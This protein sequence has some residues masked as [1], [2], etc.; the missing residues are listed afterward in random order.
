MSAFGTAVIR[1]QLKTKAERHS[2]V[3]LPLTA[4]M[5]YKR[6]MIE[7]DLII[8]EETPAPDLYALIVNN[9]INVGQGLVAA[10]TALG[11]ESSVCESLKATI[12][13]FDKRRPDIIF[14]D[15]SVPQSEVIQ[16]VDA[17]RARGFAGT[18][19]LMCGGG[20]LQLA[21]MAQKLGECGGLHLRPPLR[22][23]YRLSDIRAA[24]SA[25]SLSVM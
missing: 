18:L 2:S 11:V 4:S 22:Q 9:Q 24:I 7:T 19:Q 8:Q 15:V 25:V 21:K 1:C 16:L 23:P 14:L 6:T 13:S 20:R 17:L 5:L 10:I 3:N 12:A